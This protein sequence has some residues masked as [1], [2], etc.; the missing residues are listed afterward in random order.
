MRILH[1]IS[2]AS[3]TGEFGGPVRVALNLGLG[4]EARGHSV[5]V[6]GGQRGY[7]ECPR[8]LEGVP[9]ALFPVHSLSRRLG[10]SGL[11]SPGLYSWLWRYVADF[12]VVHVHLAREPQTLA[13]VEI[14]LA[15][16][17]PVILQTHGMVDPSSR[18]L[19]RAIDIRMRRI[20]ARAA[21]VLFLTET[22][23]RDLEHVSRRTDLPLEHLP[24]GVPLAERVQSPES[25]E[26]IVYLARLAERK[27]PGALVDAVVLLH[28]DGFPVPP[29]FFAG[30]DEGELA[31][32]MRRLESIP[33]GVSAT[34]VGA[35]SHDD[36]QKARSRGADAGA[37]GRRRAVSHVCAGG[38]EPWNPGRGYRLMRTG[39]RGPGPQ[40]RCGVGYDS[41]FF[42]RLDE[43][44]SR[45][46]R[47][48]EPRC[49]CDCNVV[50]NRIGDRD[51]RGDLRISPRVQHT[52]GESHI[53]RVRRL[54]AVVVLGEPE[55]IECQ[56]LDGLVVCSECRH[57]VRDG[58]S[59]TSRQWQ[60]CA[61]LP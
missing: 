7:P 46:R 59:V 21:R 52:S 28:E 34:Y 58:R 53:A 32:L 23:R 36:G 25:R 27:R 12:D 18:A 48:N 30:P 5:V 49:A 38:I 54:A 39:P 14:A 51:A 44:R 11:V 35:L 29:V 15:K 31:G 9:A 40:V 41:P 10:F 16:G 61:R 37:A 56:L 3:P 8:D 2:L 43:D 50:L 22:E 24:N 17:V 57:G 45:G 20:L 4:L 19:A 1:V 13:A 33:A 6:A 26:G 60:P 42:G 55:P 47:R